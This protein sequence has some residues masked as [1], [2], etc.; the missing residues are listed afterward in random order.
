MR[1]EG[2]IVNLR[3]YTIKKAIIPVTLFLIEFQSG[4]AEIHFLLFYFEG[5]SFLLQATLEVED[6]VEG[7]LSFRQD[8][9]KIYILIQSTSWQGELSF[10]YE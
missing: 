5:E 6:S 7:F 3:E 9:S 1:T 10:C 4:K 8:A 2:L